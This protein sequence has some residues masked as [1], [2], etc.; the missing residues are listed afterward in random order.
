MIACEPSSGSF[1]NNS[2]SIDDLAKEVSEL[3]TRLNVVIIILTLFIILS[4]FGQIQLVA[5]F[6]LAY[7][8]LLALVLI[9]IVV[10]VIVAI[11]IY[12]DT[13]RNPE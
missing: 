7:P 3:H 9:I 6:L 8:P 5:N 12:I 1:M 11:M 4:L 10:A 2:K 13:K